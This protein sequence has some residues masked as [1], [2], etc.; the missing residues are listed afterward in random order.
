MSALYLARAAYSM[1]NDTLRAALDG[2]G[3]VH[4]YRLRTSTQRLECV[5]YLTYAHLW[6]SSCD[7]VA[8]V[9]HIV[10]EY[11]ACCYMA[12]AQHHAILGSNRLN[13]HAGAGT[14]SVGIVV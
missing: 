3:C 6:T 5:R 4:T 7:I 2:Y 10:R 1:G 11:D 9:E 12:H 13:A 14:L 8:P